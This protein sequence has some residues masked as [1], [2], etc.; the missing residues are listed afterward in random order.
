M[1]KPKISLRKMIATAAIT[2][3][4]RRMNPMMQ[5]VAKVKPIKAAKMPKL[6]GPVNA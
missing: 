4:N 1:S 5:K 6:K 2:E 3:M